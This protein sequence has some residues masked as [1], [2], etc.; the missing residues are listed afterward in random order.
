MSEAR[1]RK[2]LGLNAAKLYK[3]DLEALKPL[4]CKFGPT[5]DQVNQPI[6]I[7]DLPRD[8]LCYLFNNAIA[9]ET[10]AA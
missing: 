5:P 1:K 10:Q 3:F 2:L 6:A 8:T 4:V 9:A 7:K